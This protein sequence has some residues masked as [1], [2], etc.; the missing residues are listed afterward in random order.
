MPLPRA[1][2]RDLEHGLGTSLGPVSLHT[3]AGAADLAAGLG[4]RAF[5][6]GRGVFLGAGSYDPGTPQGYRLLAH[7]MTHVL[8]APTA[9]ARAPLTVSTPAD[10]D[11]R[12]AV[13]ASGQAT[14]RHVSGTGPAPVLASR[15]PHTAVC[16]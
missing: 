16:A 6:V 5:T 15:A 4:A 13:L 14:E 8:Q 10:H 3:D 1:V 9:P 2:R 7:E 11:E 12:D